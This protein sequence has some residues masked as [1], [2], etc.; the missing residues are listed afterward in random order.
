MSKSNFKRTHI[1]TLCC[2]G[3]FVLLLIQ[4][5]LYADSFTLNLGDTGGTLI[6][7]MIQLSALMALLTLAPSIIVVLTSFTRIVVVFS[8]LRN[9]IG[10]QQSPPNMILISL[11]LFLT[12]FI[13]GPIFN[14][15]YTDGIAP[16]M[17]EKISYE[18]AYEKISSPFHVFMRKNVREKDLELFM[19]LGKETDLKSAK[20]ISMKTLIPAFVISE[21]RRGF[22]IG[23][24]IY[25][26]F[27]VIDMMIASILMSMGMMMLPPMLIAMPFKIVFFVLIDGWNLLCGSL[28]NSFST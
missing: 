22:E 24:L 7:R 26:P 20:D 2:L 8:F 28:V 5:P 25:L 10:T 11:A 16:L 23:F 9:A 27:V 15:S 17:E 18:E 6:G 19:R 3:A 13:M 14:K 21:L 4:T 12:L 1:N